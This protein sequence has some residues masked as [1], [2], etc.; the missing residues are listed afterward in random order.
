MS[1]EIWRPVPDFEGLYEVSSMGRV[2]SVP[3]VITMCDGRRKPITGRI[4]CQTRCDGNRLKVSLWRENIGY[5]RI[6]SR[7][8]ARA[9]LGEPQTPGLEAC[10]E[11]G[12]QD[13]NRLDNLRWDTH[14]GN[15]ADKLRHGTRLMGEKHS[16]AKITADDV[17]R[18]RASRVHHET[19]A[20]RYGVHPHHIQRIQ[21]GDRW[22]HVA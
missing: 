17:R 8:V 22:K 7:L 11:D 5:N 16:N 21:R 3:R 6:V 12:N 1:E 4:L 18:I 19:L 10:H 14:V 13:N 9:F 20:A 15:E 2:R